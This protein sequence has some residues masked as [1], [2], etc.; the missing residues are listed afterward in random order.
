[1]KRFFS[2]LIGLIIL[3]V[4]IPT[5]AHSNFAVM[6]N[7]TCGVPLAPKALFETTLPNRVVEAKTFEENLKATVTASG[8]M[9]VLLFL[10]CDE[11]FRALYTNWMSKAAN[12]VEYAEDFYFAYYNINWDVSG[13]ASWSSNNA[14]KD[15]AL[16]N[17][18]ISECGTGSG[19]GHIMVAFTGQ[20]GN[21]AGGWGKVGS[22]YS[23]VINQSDSANRTVAR[24]EVGHNYGM[25]HCTQD[26]FM[27]GG[28]K[29]YN[30]YNNICS[31]HD[32]HMDYARTAYGDE[33]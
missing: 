14:N 4:S 30:N 11:E 12:T 16:L 3:M 19:T 8:Y 17:E 21:T 7:D 10:P 24:H 18:A 25:N 22:P 1:M 13:Y 23:L 32:A 26:C 33:Q 9:Q 27:N 15:T 6:V 31:P 28:S 20:G 2:I 29:M 5:L